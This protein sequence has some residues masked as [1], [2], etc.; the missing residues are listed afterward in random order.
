MRFDLQAHSLQSDGTLPP[1]EVV[2]R[3]HAAGVEL[4]ALSDHDTVAGVA[5]ARARAAD[6]GMRY[7][8]AAEI[9]S[10]EGPH[11]DIHILGYEIDIEHPGLLAALEDYRADRQTRTE[12]IVGRLEDLGFAIDPAPLEQRRAEGKPIGRPHIADSLLGHPKN[13]N[14][15]AAEGITDKNSLFPK[16][17]VPGAPG[18]VSR[19]HPTVQEA[20][21][22]IHAAGGVAI[23]AHPFWDLDDPDEVL[24]TL[25][26]F[27][28]Q[29]VDGVEVFYPT[30]SLEQTHLLHDAATGRGMLITGS[31]DF[32]S[33][34]HERFGG[35]CG[36]ELHGREP[37]LGPIGSTTP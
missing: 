20:I 29:G 28:Q 10:V 6:L 14:R 1:A 25:A 11:D 30:H 27:A 2:E 36:F 8:T 4:F 15:L 19:S 22:L 5:E 34:D 3:A 37:N 9:S 16:Y 13:Q 32:H 18:F 7:S 17:L 24:S 31:T 35:F 12:A 23:W 33:P 26:R 21:E